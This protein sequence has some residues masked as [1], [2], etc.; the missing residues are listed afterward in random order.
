MG[1]FALVGA[2]GCAADAGGA[3]ESLMGGA[4]GFTALGRLG[5][6]T[7]GCAACPPACEVGVKQKKAWDEEEKWGWGKLT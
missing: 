6:W 4:V 7:A 3:I 2:A 1:A 5:G